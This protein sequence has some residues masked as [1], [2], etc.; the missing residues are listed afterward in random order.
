VPTRSTPS[1]RL[2]ITAHYK[3]RTTC[4]LSYYSVLLCCSTIWYAAAAAGDTLTL[5]DFTP[6]PRICNLGDIYSVHNKF[7]LDWNQVDM[8]EVQ[9]EEGKDNK[10][11]LGMRILFTCTPGRTKSLTTRS[12][13]DSG[14]S[15]QSTYTRRSNA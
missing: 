1:Q 13:L 3:M 15:A 12:L 9:A 8:P 5:K 2:I 6:P 7:Q 10:W 4:R 11:R 14:Y